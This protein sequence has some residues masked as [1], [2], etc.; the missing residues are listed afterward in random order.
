MNKPYTK[1]RPFQLDLVLVFV[2]L[3]I[4]SVVAV[5]AY[6]YYSNCEVTLDVSRDLVSQ[7]ADTVISE[8]VQYLSSAV[9]STEAIADAL[10]SLDMTLADTRDG[11]KSIELLL[12]ALMKSH[13]SLAMLYV[14][15][16][17]G[18]FF[19]ISRSNDQIL[20]R[21]ISKGLDGRVEQYFGCTN[22]MSAVYD[23]RTRPWYT[24]AAESRKRYWT[25]P[26][27]F[28][29]TGEIGV[30]ASFPVF[31]SD[32]S[33]RAVVGADITLQALSL[34]LKKVRV[35]EHGLAFIVDRNI[36]LVAYPDVSKVVRH[37]S[38]GLETVSAFD[39]AEPWIVEAVSTYLKTDGAA[40]SFESGGQRYLARL[41]EPPAT[42]GTDWTV[43][44]MVPEDDFVGKIKSAHRV[45]MLITV[46]IMGLAILCGVHFSRTVS[47][48]IERLSME[49]QRVR[50]FDLLGELKLNSHV[51]EIQ[52]MLDAFR[53]MRQGLHAFGRYVPTYLVKE[54]VA[55]GREPIPGGEERIMTIFFSDIANFTTI[56]QS[57]PPSE[58]MVDLSSYFDILS[59]IIAKYGGVVDKYIGDGA[60]AFWN[61]PHDNP[62]HALQAC[63]AAIAC[64]KG[65]AELNVRREADG[66]PSF[67][68]RVGIHSD[69]VVVGNLGGVDR[70]N[71]TVIGDGVNVASRM[72]GA[73]KNL[74][75][76]IIISAA[77]LALLPAD[78]RLTLQDMGE[79]TLRGKDMPI[80]VYSIS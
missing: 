46:G 52:Q 49:M 48:P 78:H 72:E 62:E 41:R 4:V 12:H 1:G 7:T 53:A 51:R 13:P 18:R 67:H 70:L 39:L 15:D 57:I 25:P 59:S 34:F 50:N 66:K 47:R 44:V 40:W 42:L 37:S 61:A 17:D 10:N 14:G 76:Q 30:T 28:E 21:L 64:Q 16:K 63:R 65:I 45:T 24:G 29:S 20:L 23:P 35:G 56:S 19:E 55:D 22:T 3:V 33:I 36:K 69:K 26:Y 71:Y 27:I 79:I 38:K 74:G 32:G 75:T 58:L 2:S 8:T 9:R 54:L 77:T 43:V 31:A 73:N 60:L 11:N 5:A 6:A 68:T 80:R